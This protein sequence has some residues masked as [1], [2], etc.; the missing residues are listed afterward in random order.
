MATFSFS[1]VSNPL[2]AKYVKIVQHDSPSPGTDVEYRIYQSHDP[3]LVRDTNANIFSLYINGFY[4]QIFTH[5]EVIAPSFTTPDDLFNKLTAMFGAV[6][7]TTVTVANFPATQTV[8][9]AVTV[10]GSVNATIVGSVSAT[11][12]GGVVLGDRSLTRFYSENVTNV[13]QTVKTGAGKLYQVRLVNP[14]STALLEH[15]V[16]LKAFDTAGAVTIGTTPS[17][18]MWTVGVSDEAERDY[19][20][21]PYLF[22][23][24]LK[25]CAVQDISLGSLLAPPKPIVVELFFA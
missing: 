20:D 8:N 11:I 7:E 10:S 19:E 2:E 24:G 3:I 9:G 5:T 4:G 22:T 21:K 13:V 16:V 17:S 15:R 23:N 1:L 18:N 6:N 12:T 25:I 14:D